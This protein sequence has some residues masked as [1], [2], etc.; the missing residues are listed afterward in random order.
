MMFAVSLLYMAFIKNFFFLYMAF[1]VLRFFP[2]MPTFWMKGC[3]MLLDL[4]I[5]YFENDYG[6]QNNLQIQCNSLSNNQS[7]FSQN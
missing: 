1:I 7:H 4:K 6:T 5:Q 2:S 3:S